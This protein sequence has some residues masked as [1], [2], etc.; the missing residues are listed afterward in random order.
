[1][2]KFFIQWD[3]RYRNKATRNYGGRNE[4]SKVN[5][6]IAVL[7]TMPNPHRLCYREGQFSGN[8]TLMIFEG[9]KD[10]GCFTDK[11]RK[12]LIHVGTG[13]FVPKSIVRKT[14]RKRKKKCKKSQNSQETK[15]SAKSI[16][17]DFNSPS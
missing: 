15:V 1:M 12:S 9:L 6:A 5:H 11:K 10:I 4:F 17:L 14:T 7:K 3:G 8:R 16:P 2:I 13:M